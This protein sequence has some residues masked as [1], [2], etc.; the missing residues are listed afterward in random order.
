MSRGQLIL[1]VAIIA[2]AGRGLA[3]SAKDFLR[4]V[5]Q[6]ETRRLQALLTKQ[7]ALV[8][9]RF[10]NNATALHIAAGYGRVDIIRLLLQKGADIHAKD[11]YG[12]TPLHYAVL[13]KQHQALVELLRRGANVNDASFGGLTPLHLA[14]RIDDTVAINILLSRGARLDAKSVIGTPLHEA[15]RWRRTSAAQLLLQKGASVS[16]L[17]PQGGTPLH[18]AA[19]NDALAVAQLLLQRRARVDARD[20]DGNTPLHWACYYGGARLSTVKWLLDR[21]ADPN[22]KNR[23]GETALHR[24]AASYW[25]YQIHEGVA[26]KH[27]KPEATIRAEREKYVQNAVAIARLLAQRGAAVDAVDASGHTAADLARAQGVIELEREL[28]KLGRH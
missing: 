23:R 27:P 17:D 15:A 8:S 11:R 25:F 4:F 9:A 3:D 21:G 18:A 26:R 22:A 5:E 12:V 20:R 2:I 19:C 28:R 7:P 10:A 6:G 13:K 14:A 24:L 1:C 16:A